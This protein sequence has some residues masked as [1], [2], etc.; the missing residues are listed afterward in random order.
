MGAVVARGARDDGVEVLRVALRFHERHAAA[1][2]AAVEIREARRAAIERGGRGLALHRGFVDRAIA[3]VNQLLG[4]PD[5]EAGVGAGVAGVGRGDGVAA[6]Q[7]LAERAVLN[8]AAPR[9]VADREE[10]AVPARRRQPHF[11]L[12]VGVAR[13]LD[14]QRHAAERREAGR[15]LRGAGAAAGLHEFAG[16]HEFG[17]AHRRIRELQRGGQLLARG[18]GHR[19]RLHGGGKNGKHGGEYRDSHGYTPTGNLKVSGYR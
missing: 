18:C 1:A 19:L 16:R 15:G 14:R 9:A 4:M 8:R 12:D 3:E 13:R 17:G 6:L 2:G 11:R 10:L 7:T 5:R